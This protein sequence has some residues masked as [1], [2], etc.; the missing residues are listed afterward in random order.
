METLDDSCEV[1][2][3]TVAALIRMY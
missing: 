2:I 3:K 1:V